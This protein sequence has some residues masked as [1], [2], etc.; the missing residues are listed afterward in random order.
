M[1]ADGKA[2]R[3]NVTNW[4]KKFNVDMLELARQSAQE[5]SY[6]VVLN[7]RV[8]VGFLRGSWQPSLNEPVTA[9]PQPGAENGANV[10]Q[11]ST[12]LTGLKLGDRFWMTNNAAYALRIEFGF[13]GADKLGRVYNQAGDY[14]VTSHAKRWPKIVADV[15]KGLAGLQ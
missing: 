7:T 4:A 14:N 1:A 9:K 8:D 6:R 15:A 13:V 12:V 3:A 10:A 5:L 11:I 2:F